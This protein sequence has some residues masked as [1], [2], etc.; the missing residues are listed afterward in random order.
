VIK[1]KKQAISLAKYNLQE[2]LDYF[3]MLYVGIQIYTAYGD[4]YSAD[5]CKKYLLEIPDML[6]EVLDTTDALAWKITDVPE[7]ELPE[8][9]LEV[10]EE[11]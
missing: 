7:L 11:F 2:Y 3:D 5:Y 1:Y 8:E 9:Y 4:S 6:T 10:L